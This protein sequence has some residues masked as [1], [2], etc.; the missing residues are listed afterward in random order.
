M[1]PGARC[2]EKF[3]V[4]EA[5]EW[6]MAILSQIPH[7]GYT[8]RVEIPVKYSSIHQLSVERDVNSARDLATSA[9]TSDQS[10]VLPIS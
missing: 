4:F 3:G 9:T 6:E 7:L 5:S 2:K 1:G 10:V 8:I